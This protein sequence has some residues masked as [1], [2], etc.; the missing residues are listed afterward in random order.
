MRSDSVLTTKKIKSLTYPCFLIF[1]EGGN[2]RRV[3]PPIGIHYSCHSSVT[4]TVGVQGIYSSRSTN[5]ISHYSFPFNMTVEREN[6]IANLRSNSEFVIDDVLKNFPSCSSKVISQIEYLRKLRAENEAFKELQPAKIRS[7]FGINRKTTNRVYAESHDESRGF[8][9][10]LTSEE[11]NHV[12]S[13]FR[14]SGSNLTEG[15][16]SLREKFSKSNKDFKLERG[17]FYKYHKAFKDANP[18]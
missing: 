2:T 12:E 15:S 7:L 6:I 9:N 10:R 8:R 17:A 16:E 18:Q 11:L 14:E 4:R 5:H 13:F 1:C 3:Y